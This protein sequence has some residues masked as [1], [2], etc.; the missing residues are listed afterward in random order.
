VPIP[1]CGCAISRS[2]RF[3][4][5]AIDGISRFLMAARQSKL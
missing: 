2:V 1:T 5:S 4:V 3:E